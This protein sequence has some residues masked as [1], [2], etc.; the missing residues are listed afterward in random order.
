MQNMKIEVYRF[1]SEASK[2][3]KRATSAWNVDNT[4]SLMVI[5]SPNPFRRASTAVVPG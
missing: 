3:P 4:F 2:S 1:E 5:K